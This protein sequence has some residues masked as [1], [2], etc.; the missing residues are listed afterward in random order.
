MGNKI[1]PWGIEAKNK[2]ERG[3]IDFTDPAETKR[4]TFYDCLACNQ[5]SKCLYKT[6]PTA[7]LEERRT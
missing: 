6:K 5:K 7:K 1:C 2:A 3:E 4:K